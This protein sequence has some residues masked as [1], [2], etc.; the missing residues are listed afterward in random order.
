MKES[1]DSFT[2]LDRQAISDALSFAYRYREK[3][4]EAIK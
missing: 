1:L 2:K 4:E 3:D